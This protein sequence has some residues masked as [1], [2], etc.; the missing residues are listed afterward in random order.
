MANKTRKAK[1]FECQYI[2]LNPK[3]NVLRISDAIFIFIFYF[4]YGIFINSRLLLLLKSK[5]IDK[6]SMAS[7]LKID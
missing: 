1:I 5:L 7:K 2:F 3:F 4:L 6:P